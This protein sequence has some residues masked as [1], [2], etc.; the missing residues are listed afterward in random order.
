MSARRPVERGGAPDR[1]RAA[2]CSTWDVRR[3][4]PRGTCGGMFHVGRRGGISHVGRR[5][6]MFHVGRA[7]ACSTWDVR[8]HVPRGTALRHVPRGTCGGISHVGR[9]AA[10]STWDVRRHLSRGTP[11]APAGRR[12]TTPAGR[13]LASAPSAMPSPTAS[14]APAATPRRC[15]PL[16]RI[17]DKT[18]GIRPGSSG[19][20]PM[21]G[22]P[23]VSGAGRQAIGVGAGAP[24][25]V[26][27]GRA[28]AASCRGRRA[29]SRRWRSGSR[30]RRRSR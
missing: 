10:C 21:P 3:H 28:T 13:D 30:A 23:A 18:A 15:V 12:A 1:W 29:P 2:A 26:S 11:R 25:A 9:A 5:G 8:R 16:V 7:A 4:L 14:R 24:A 6:G 17:S 19:Q 22:Q 20:P 27:A